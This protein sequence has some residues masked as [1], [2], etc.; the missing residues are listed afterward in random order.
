MTP[1]EQRTVEEIVR[2]LRYGPPW[3]ARQVKVKVEQDGV[4]VTREQPEDSPN[5]RNGLLW[6]V[7][8][9]IEKRWLRS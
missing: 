2:W 6:L 7:A 1:E 5:T 8:D 4:M 3:V 9:M